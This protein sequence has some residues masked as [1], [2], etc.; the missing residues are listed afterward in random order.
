MDKV[1]LTS[2]L[3]VLSQ[4]RRFCIDLLLDDL[5]IKRAFFKYRHSQ[6][7]MSL[8]IDKYKTECLNHY[9]ELATGRDNS[10]RD[11]ITRIVSSLIEENV[12]SGCTELCI[13]LLNAK[14]DVINNMIATGNNMNSRYKE[15]LVAIERDKARYEDEIERIE[16]T[17]KI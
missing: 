3:D 15:L 4:G 5:D 10:V 13:A 17:M 2:A 11:T 6:P 14:K 16:K 12:K 9:L 7:I 1:S 8:V